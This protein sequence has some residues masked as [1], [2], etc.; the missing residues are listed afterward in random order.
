MDDEDGYACACDIR[1]SVKAYICS[2]QLAEVQ[3]L[4]LEHLTETNVPGK[5][6]DMGRETFPVDVRVPDC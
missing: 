1:E 5:I 3:F 6:S 4:P 2:D